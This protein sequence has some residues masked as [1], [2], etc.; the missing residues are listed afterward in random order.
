M[1]GKCLKEEFKQIKERIDSGIVD[2]NALL[3]LESNYEDPLQR[4]IN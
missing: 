4:L 3:A 1:S 2:I